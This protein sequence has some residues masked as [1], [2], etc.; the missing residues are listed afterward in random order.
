MLSGLFG[1]GGAAG[2]A[3]IPGANSNKMLGALGLGSMGATT[4]KAPSM[5]DMYGD[6]RGRYTRT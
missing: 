3:T 1:G 5:E 4:P 6:T 2:M